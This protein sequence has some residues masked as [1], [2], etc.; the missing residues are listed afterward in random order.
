MKKRTASKPRKP[1][2]TICAAGSGTRL[3]II[4]SEKDIRQRVRELARQIN[5][6]YAGKTL[7]IVG[8]LEDGFVFMADL[9]R[10]LEGDVV[11][12]FLKAYVTE[13]PREGGS[14]LELFFRPELEVAGKHVL[15][16]MGVLQTGITSEFLIRHLTSCGA[17]SVR[18]ATFI[19][20]STDRRIL[21]R[22]DYSGFL[23]DNSYVVGYG[24]GTADFGR[25]LPFLA[26][27]QGQLPP[28]PG[29]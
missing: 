27:V 19:D 4:V 3:K 8:I 18:I 24:L 15:L 14:T 20:R 29:I 10:A 13:Q 23:L 25:N 21:L 6:D 11:C 1:P 17:A 12:Q 7:H 28:S 5:R 9:V 22:A 2:K 16:V 26:V